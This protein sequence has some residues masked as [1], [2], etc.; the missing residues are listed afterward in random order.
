MKEWEGWKRP[1]DKD[2]VGADAEDHEDGKGL[3]RAEV[4][5][6]EDEAIDHE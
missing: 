5:D 3:Q 2:I 1:E 4:G 6:A